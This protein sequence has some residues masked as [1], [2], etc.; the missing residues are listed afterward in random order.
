MSAFS[1]ISRI[2]PVRSPLSASRTGGVPSPSRLTLTESSSPGGRTARAAVMA[3]ASSSIQVPSWRAAA[4]TVGGVAVREPAQRLD[5]DRL[6]GGEVDD[7]LQDDLRL[8][9]E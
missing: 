7:R 2:T 6:A 9:G 1:V 8:H 3:A 5:R 4:N